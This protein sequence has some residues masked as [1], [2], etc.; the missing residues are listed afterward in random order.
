MSQPSSQNIDNYITRNCED[1]RNPSVKAVLY[2]IHSGKRSSVRRLDEA[3]KPYYMDIYE[4]KDGFLF[5]S[6]I[7]LS[8]LD[9]FFTLQIL[10]RGGIEINPV[11][12]ALLEINNTVFIVGKMSITSICLLFV[13]I[14][15]NF[16]LF[17]IF[18]IRSFMMCL[19]SFYVL[20]IGYEMS[21]LA[22]I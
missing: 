2:A 4:P 19:A 22:T 3:S 7:V 15:I 12:A 8:T 13:L 9:S 11:M 17:R 14:H 18:S 1:R 21:L 16:K 20:L 6:I 10:D 5:L